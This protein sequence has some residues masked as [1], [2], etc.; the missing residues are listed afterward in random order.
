MSYRHKK[1]KLIFFLLFLVGLT[2]LLT[3]LVKGHN[4]ALFNSKGPI[5][6]AEGNLIVT[7]V[8]FMF[9]LVIP[10]FVFTFFV[11]WK[12]RAGNREEKP[13][14]EPVHNHGIEFFWWFLPS[15]II[16]ILAVITWQSTHALDPFKPLVSDKKAITI[17]VVSLQ[18]KWL[19]IYPEQ[20]IATVNFIEFPFNTPVNFELTADAPMNSFWIPQ[21][22]GQMY[23]MPGM[24]TQLHV[25]AT[26]PGEFSG[27]AAEIN[28]QGFSGMKFMA[29]AD[30]KAD[31][32]AWVKSVKASSKYL[33]FNE[34]N[35]LAKPSENNPVIFYSEAEMNLYNKIIMKFMPASPAGGPSAPGSPMPKMQGMEY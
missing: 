6:A 30:S 13:V 10:V 22:A 31:F 23:A 3:T 25:M 32:E 7:A 14:L 17:Q 12:Y 24:S 8:A 33:D 11:V 5:A 21:L 16:F 27:S 26:S 28:G 1:Y 2:V 35:E 4:V 20:N 34:Y 9:A 15:A 19:F 29:K 18:W